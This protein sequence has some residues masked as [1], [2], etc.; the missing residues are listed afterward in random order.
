MQRP[1]DWVFQSELSCPGF[2]PVRIV[3]WHDDLATVGAYPARVV[4]SPANTI[5]VRTGQRET[6]Q[7]SLD[8]S[9]M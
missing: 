7:F 3:L 8:P 1:R 9:K 4:K 5:R 6:L 2:D